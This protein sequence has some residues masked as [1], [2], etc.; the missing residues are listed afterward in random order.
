MNAVLSGGVAAAVAAAIVWLARTWISERLRGALERRLEAIAVF[1]KGMM[2]WRAALPSPTTMLDVFTE[3]DLRTGKFLE[4]E[5]GFGVAHLDYS[6]IQIGSSIDPPV[7]RARPFAT[8]YM[9]GLYFAYRAF[10][11]QMV[12]NLQLAGKRGSMEPWF[13]DKQIRDLLLRAMGKVQFDKWDSD[14]AYKMLRAFEAIENRMLEHVGEIISGK[15]SAD[16]MLEQ[17]QS[18]M[19]AAARLR[20]D[21]WPNAGPV[22]GR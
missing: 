22:K 5:F 13:R 3:D 20:P 15:A 11:C 17:T 18:I 10:L 1:W 19:A 8:P 6:W 14:P 4:G 9:Y 21:Q 7:D 12:G 16:L 2:D